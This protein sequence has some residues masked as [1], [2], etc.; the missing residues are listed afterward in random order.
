MVAPNSRLVQ[1][2][3]RLVAG[4]IS[5]DTA[6][7]LGG[8]A[9]HIWALSSSPEKKITKE[10][11]DAIIKKLESGET[12]NFSEEELKYVEQLKNELRLGAPKSN[13]PLES[14][15]S[16][17]GGYGRSIMSDAERKLLDAQAAAA[18]GQIK[19]GAEV[20][21]I[22]DALRGQ[23]TKQ[24]DAA[25]RARA[26]EF[27][28]NQEAVQSVVDL[29]ERAGKFVS[30]TAEYKTIIA[31][32][33]AQLDNSVAMQRS[34]DVQNSLRKMLTELTN[35]EK[36]AAEKKLTLSGQ[37]LDWVET[38][39]KAKSVSFQAIDDVRR[40]LGEVFK[41]KPSEGYEALKD[42]EIGKALYSQLR[43]L[44]VKYA[45]P[46]QESLLSAYHAGSQELQQFQT[47]LGKKA[48]ALDQWM[49]GH[50]GTDAAALPASFFKTK[51]S[52]Q[53]L[54]ELTGNQALVNTA[55]LQYADRQLAGKDAAGVR[56]WLA[57]NTEWLSQAGN[58]RV[59]IDN[60]ASKLEG[61]ER[62]VRIAEEFASK[63]SANKNLLVG[64][65]IP[66]NQ[67]VAL[68]ESK[69]AAFWDAAM[70]A[71]TASPQ[72]KTDTLN[73]VRQVVANKATTHG[74]EDLFELSIRP[75]LE[76]GGIASKAEMDFMAKKLAEIRELKVP[77]EAKLGMWKR[78]ILNAAGG[79]S[80]TIAG[81][82]T[83]WAKDKVIPE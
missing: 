51:A 64:K 52:M 57:D 27:G 22:G 41:G 77:E 30:D 7:A 43:D 58:A 13:D 39:G 66:A 3:T 56:K 38:P 8:V 33:E 37:N 48:T 5:P 21:D 35:A 79:W 69:N 76:K 62:N 20:S 18:G 19:P 61:L 26:A 72:A 47:K 44:Q 83:T 11:A 59:L 82:G 17:M 49:E 70:P 60:Y 67:A 63:A 53:A 6:R 24:Q 80:A 74:I 54:R 32:L 28:K 4:A 25:M 45:G 46:P 36:S 16:L 71:I 42:T 14:T 1:E 12:R 65:G 40:K 2:G 78:L 10:V 9:R 34:P 73:A 55:A 75:F 29:K 81:R 31:M 23:I 15:G 50:Y 68:I